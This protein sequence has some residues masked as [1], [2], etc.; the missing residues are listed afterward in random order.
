MAYAAYRLVPQYHKTQFAPGGCV[1]DV[2]PGI[3]ARPLLAPVVRRS[4][5]HCY[6]S[7]L[8]TGVD[9]PF[10]VPSGLRLGEG[11]TGRRSLSRSC[12]LGDGHS[13]ARLFEAV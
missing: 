3:V 6:M 7:R 4:D 11:G 9:S 2:S 5:C 8:T 13:Q 12:Q 1:V 10:S